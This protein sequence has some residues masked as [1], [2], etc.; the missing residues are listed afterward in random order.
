MPSAADA[1]HQI[2]QNQVATRNLHKLEGRH[3]SVL[4]YMHKHK[5]FDEDA[6]LC[7]DT[8][9]GRLAHASL[10]AGLTGGPGLTSAGTI[11]FQPHLVK[12][13]SVTDFS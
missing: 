13:Y 7:M 5:V 8:T 9:M 12:W 1:P 2:H 6:W 4:Q 11:L 3:Y 10:Q